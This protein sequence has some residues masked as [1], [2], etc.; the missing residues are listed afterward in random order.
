MM[1]PEQETFCLELITYA[2]NGRA[3]S[4]EALRAA[5]SGDFAKA[6]AHPDQVLE[7]LRAGRSETKR[8]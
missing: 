5:K 7:A 3:E 8:G 1:T 4:Y 2:G 6:E